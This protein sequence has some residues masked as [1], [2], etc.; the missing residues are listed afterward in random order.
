MCVGGGLA[1]FSGIFLSVFLSFFSFSPLRSHSMDGD[2]VI[3]ALQGQTIWP[4][5]WPPVQEGGWGWGGGGRATGEEGA[6]RRISLQSTDTLL[7]Y[8]TLSLPL[9]PHTLAFASHTH[10]FNPTLVNEA[11][12]QRAHLNRTYVF[13]FCHEFGFRT[14]VPAPDQTFDSSASRHLPG[15][16]ANVTEK[17]AKHQALFL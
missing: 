12:E 11:R 15:V 2:T 6:E 17:V 16:S 14:K 3:K 10:H 13:I 7:N 5:Q 9:P 8:S 4:R 1:F